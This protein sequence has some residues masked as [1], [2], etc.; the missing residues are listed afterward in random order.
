MGRGQELSACSRGLNKLPSDLPS[1][2]ASGPILHPSPSWGPKL[3][4][5]ITLPGT[6]PARRARS[7]VSQLLSG[8]RWVPCKPPAHPLPGPGLHTPSSCPAGLGLMTHSGSRGL[9]SGWGDS[10]AQVGSRRCQDWGEAEAGSSQE[11]E[12][13]C[14]APASSRNCPVHESAHPRLSCQGA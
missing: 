4:A 13:P 8:M 10:A 12:H 3:S 5:G 1:I 7:D 9:D 2:T 11:P 14:S 6:W